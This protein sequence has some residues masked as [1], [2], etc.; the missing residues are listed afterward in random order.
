[1]PIKYLILEYVVLDDRIA[2]LVLIDDIRYFAQQEEYIS[3]PK[4]L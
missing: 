2:M 3:N 1:M 4:I